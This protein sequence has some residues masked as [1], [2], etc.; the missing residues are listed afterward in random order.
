LD[1]DYLVEVAGSQGPLGDG[2][3]AGEHEGGPFLVGRG[4]LVEPNFASGYSSG[5]VAS[6]SQL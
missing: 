4:K 3:V 1:I 2:A 5:H 6:D